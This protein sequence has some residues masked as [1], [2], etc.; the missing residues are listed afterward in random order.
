VVSSLV[1]RATGCQTWRFPQPILGLGGSRIQ[2]KYHCRK[3]SS[4]A[5][6]TLVLSVDTEAACRHR[7]RGLCAMIMVLMC[8]GR[9]TL[10]PL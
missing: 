9:C 4:R 3:Q 10:L 1:R 2:A 6:S 5:R 8:E 7:C